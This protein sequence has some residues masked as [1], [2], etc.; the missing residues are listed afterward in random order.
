[1]SLT[2]DPRLKQIVRERCR[3]F[4]K[5]Q[6]PAEKIFWEAVRNRKV[7][8]LKFY[9]QYPIFF[10]Y[11]GKE[12]FYIADFYCHEKKLVIE[13]DGKIHERQ[14]AQDEIRTFVINLLGM[15][16]L[17]FGNEEVLNRLPA[18]LERLEA[19]VR[20]RGFE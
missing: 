12:T 14:Q 5:R 15:E 1:M 4:R 17:R 2:K 16:V 18:V 7:M 10:D 13:I 11:F 8:G 20:M 19:V 3:E 9:R 6:T